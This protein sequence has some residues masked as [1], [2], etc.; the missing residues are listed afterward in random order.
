MSILRPEEGKTTGHE[1]LSRSGVKFPVVMPLLFLHP[2][3]FNLFYGPASL[4]LPVAP[5]PSTTAP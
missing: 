3:T 2:S 5:S 1:L 4:P